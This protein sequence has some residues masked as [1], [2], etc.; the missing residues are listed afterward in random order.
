[1]KAL[2][3]NETQLVLSTALVRASEGVLDSDLNRGIKGWSGLYGVE[4]EMQF[5]TIDL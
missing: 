1:M 4:I 2:R 3:W 5:R